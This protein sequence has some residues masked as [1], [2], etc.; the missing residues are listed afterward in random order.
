MSDGLGQGNCKKGRIKK[1]LV[2]TRFLQGGLFPTGKNEGW[3]AQDFEG[4]VW[5]LFY[6]FTL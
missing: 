3:K 5:R 1:I 4:I 2:E 6:H